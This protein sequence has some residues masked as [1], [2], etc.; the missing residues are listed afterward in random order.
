M[1]GPDYT[2]TLYGVQRSASQARPQ[3]DVEVPEHGVAATGEPGWASES[4]PAT[5]APVDLGTFAPLSRPLGEP[6]QALPQAAVVEESAASTSDVVLSRTVAA[7]GMIS[8]PSSRTSA[9]AAPS[10]RAT[11]LATG[12]G[13]T[14]VS[15]ATT[16]VAA[17]VPEG[18]R[19]GTVYG[20]NPPQ[21]G[22]GR[23]PSG[24]LAR[25]HIG[26]HSASLAALSMMGVP[27]ATT[28]PAASRPVGPTGHLRAG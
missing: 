24:R 11:S 4:V 9:G 25:L 20:G 21:R 6:D 15:E 7:S 10:A 16:R 19:N 26:W 3:P 12:L 8:R 27:P 23:G 5:V 2:G 14:A 17:P 22:G 18:P 13:A 1:T 28:A